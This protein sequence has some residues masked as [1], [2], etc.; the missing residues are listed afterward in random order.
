MSAPPADNWPHT[1]R[2]MPWLIAAFLVML[3]L[4]PFDEI[5]FKVHLPMDSKPDRVVLG[6]MILVWI[7]RAWQGKTRGN[8]RRRTSLERA[9]LVYTGIVLLS[10]VLNIDRMVQLNELTFAEKRLFQL[11]GY[12]IFFFLVAST[13]R[14]AE[15][16]AYTK[17]ILTLTCITALGTLYE[18]HTGY[19]VFYLW[20][21]KI[22][23]PIAS[24][25]PPPTAINLSYGRP[26]VVGPTAHGLAVTSMLTIALP[27]A[28][29]PLLQAKTL[30][31]RLGY[32][33]VIGLILAAELSTARKT[34][35]IA[36]MGA[37][38]VLVAY[39]RKLLRWSPL[40]VI[41]LIP[42]IHFAAPGTI[43][44]LTS[45]LGSAKSSDSTAG[46]V[47]D[48][49]AVAPDIYAHLITGSGYGTL[50][51]DNY[52]WY[53]ILDNEYLD[54]LFQLGLLGL[55]SYLAIVVCAVTTA[56]RVIKRG[57]PRAPPTL[58]AAAGCVAYGVVSATFDATGFPQAPYTFLF[59]A[60]LIVVTAASQRKED[61]AA[62]DASLMHVN[63]LYLEP[64]LHARGGPS[65][66]YDTTDSPSL[67]SF[68]AGNAALQR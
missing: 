33:I 7:C 27:F 60:A 40:A 26:T 37:F 66:A 36:P 53:R 68:A 14:M 38:V 32:I 57:G 10:I 5:S 44:T 15:I 64:A 4:V 41:A 6:L 17:L 22:L 19:N 3:F 25:L 56:H 48:Y 58:A 55:L 9:L 67:S 45:I 35:F 46:R 21:A 51:P 11:L 13:V 29:L 47:S 12:V 20:S 30:R 28:V 23:K 42:V 16:P 59:A 43:G 2:P 49:S 39:N 1:R 8:R 65:D 50:N 63:R 62:E 18:A 24:V 52:R 54:E 31:K 34:A 61:K